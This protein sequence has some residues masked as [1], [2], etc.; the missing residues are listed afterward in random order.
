MDQGGEASKYGERIHKYL[1]DRLNGSGLLP[2]EVQHYE[3]LCQ[4]VEQAATGGQLL[5]EQELCLN[6]TLS[7]TGW[8]DPDAWLR[9]KLDIL[10]LKGADANVMDWKSGKRYP[11]FFQ[12]QVFAA[13]VFKHYPE[14]QR[15]KTSLVWLKDM[16]MDT[17][18]YTRIDMNVLWAEIMARIRRIYDSL[19]HDNW[20]ARPSGLC[21]YCPVR[22]DC[23][24]ARV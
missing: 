15:V 16:A 19:E 23:T 10:I 6:E 2:A 3:V 21:R 8:W 1:E 11:D 14:V 13:Q 17:E 4:A 12:M 24:S 20:P 5:I 22:H 9:S 18:Q 7:P